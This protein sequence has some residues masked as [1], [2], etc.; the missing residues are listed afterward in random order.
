[1]PSSEPRAGLFIFIAKKGKRSIIRGDAV[2][3][4]AIAI[5]AWISGHY[6]CPRL[7]CKDSRNPEK[8]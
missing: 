8:C 2:R 1:M 6:C 5:G 4:K 7:N 3:G